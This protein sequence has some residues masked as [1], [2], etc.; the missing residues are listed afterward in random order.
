[1][2]QMAADSGKDGLTT[3]QERFLVA[4][5][6]HAKIKDAAASVH[7][8]E[9][10][11]RSYMSLPA[12]KA[13]YD[14]AKQDLLSEA[15]ERIQIETAKSVKVIADMRDDPECPHP[16][17]LKAAH[18]F[19]ARLTDVKPVQS[20]QPLQGDAGLIERNLLPYLTNEELTQ[21]DQLMHMAKARKQE[22]DAKAEATQVAR[23]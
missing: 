15:M 12:F 14:Q 8:A 11:A 4:L 5:L 23:Q 7:I 18:I 10:T 6:Q 13:A 22:A 3:I 9:R 2:R 1:M 16:T 17:R 19:A 21:L 20:D